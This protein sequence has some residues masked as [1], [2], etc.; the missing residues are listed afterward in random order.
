MI[1]GADEWLNLLSKQGEKVT[2]NLSNEKFDNA[3]YLTLIRLGEENLGG[4]G[5]Y[6]LETYQNK[7]INLK[8]WICE[9]TEFIFGEYPQKLYFKVVS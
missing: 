3:A 6:L 1:Q 4:G 8:I 7:K 2:V 9:V 5:N